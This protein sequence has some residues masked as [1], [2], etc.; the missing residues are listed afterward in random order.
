MQPED[1]REIM[2]PPGTS[3]G[4]IGDYGG[5]SEWSNGKLVIGT[6]K[7][8]V[9]VERHH[10][11]IEIAING[12]VWDT[13]AIISLL[14]P[15]K[16]L[17]ESGQEY[18]GSELLLIHRYPELA[19]DNKDPNVHVFGIKQSES[20]P[21]KEPLVL[22]LWKSK[23]IWLSSAAI[24]TVEESKNISDMARVFRE[25]VKRGENDENVDS[26]V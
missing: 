6:V 23:T 9:I 4:L 2:N 15:L 16:L 20:L 8:Y 1:F 7:S 13:A 5:P 19:W 21:A 10:N 11:T 22:S 18:I 14:K 25:K 24:M 26:Q 3:I 12:I 17:G